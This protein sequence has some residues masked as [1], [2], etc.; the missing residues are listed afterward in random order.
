MNKSR[1]IWATGPT[2]MY[3]H[4]PWIIFHEARNNNKIS[5]NSR[6]LPPH[7]SV[8]DGSQLQTTTQI[9]LIACVHCDTYC[10]KHTTWT[11][12]LCSTM[13]IYC[14]MQQ[15]QMYLTSRRNV[16]RRWHTLLVGQNVQMPIIVSALYW[17]F[18]TKHVY[19]R[20]LF[21]CNT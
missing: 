8:R 6:V 7:I 17:K 12:N 5:I 1:R 21:L 3:V 2:R 15:I 16:S 14:Y 10:H 19:C 9:R 4:S 13:H 18:P 20:A 11:G